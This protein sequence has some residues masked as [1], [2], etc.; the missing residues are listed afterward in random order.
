MQFSPYCIVHNSQQRCKPSNQVP[1]C[2]NIVLCTALLADLYKLLRKA[3]LCGWNSTVHQPMDRFQ[4]GSSVKK[5]QEQIQCVLRERT[6]DYNA[7]H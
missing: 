5:K 4:A 3:A 2:Q 1:G 6:L 7:A